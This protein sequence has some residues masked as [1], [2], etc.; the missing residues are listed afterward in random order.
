MAEVT[1][2]DILNKRWL[3]LNHREVGFEYFQPN[4]FVPKKTYIAQ[5]GRHVLLVFAE[6]EQASEFFNTV[7]K[8]TL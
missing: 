3:E 6:R 8:E 4:F 2:G 5:V 1:E 7:V